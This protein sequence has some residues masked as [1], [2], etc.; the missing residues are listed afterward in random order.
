MKSFFAEFVHTEKGVTCSDSGF[1]DLA[2]A[3]ECS[4]AVSYALSFNI[5][6]DYKSEGSWS[7]NPMGCYIYDYGSMHFNTHSTGIRKSSTITIC[8]KGNT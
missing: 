6:A 2:T 5:K 4:S 7:R 3:Q 8:R 1:I